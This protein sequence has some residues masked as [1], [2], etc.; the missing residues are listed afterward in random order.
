MKRLISILFL[1]YIIFSCTAPEGDNFIFDMPKFD[2]IKDC[3]N[4]ILNYVDYKGDSSGTDKWQLP[5]ETL[6][7]RKGDCE[8]FSILIMSIWYYQHGD[9]LDLVILNNE[10]GDCHAVVDYHG[11]FIQSTGT[12]KVNYKEIISRVNF[13]TAIWKAKYD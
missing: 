4:W 11:T 7:R 6:D 10:E 5:Q 9:K 12:G 3:R 1:S 13:D 2:R 8:D